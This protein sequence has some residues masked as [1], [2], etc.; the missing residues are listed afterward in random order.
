[1]QLNQRFTLCSVPV[2]LPRCSGLSRTTF[3]CFVCGKTGLSL[4]SFCQPNLFYFL[5]LFFK[6]HS[7]PGQRSEF[8][9]MHTH[10]VLPSAVISLVSNRVVTLPFT[11]CGR[12]LYLMRSSV[13]RVLNQQAPPDALLRPALRPQLD[14]EVFSTQASFTEFRLTRMLSSVDAAP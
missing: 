6:V 11:P 5:F 8:F 9:R 12:C 4:V 14:C 13:A 10:T 1:M 7:L 2:L 3:P